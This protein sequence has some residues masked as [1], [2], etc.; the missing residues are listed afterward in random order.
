MGRTKL[1][2]AL[3]ERRLRVIATAR[4]WRTVT[5]LRDLTGSPG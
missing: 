3:I 2:Q 5:R 4:N 1:S